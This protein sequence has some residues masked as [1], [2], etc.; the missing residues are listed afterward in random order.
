MVVNRLRTAMQEAEDG[1]GRTEG[2]LMCL[3][4]CCSLRNGLELPFCCGASLLN[5]LPVFVVSMAEDC[6]G[7]LSL[8]NSVIGSEE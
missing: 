8:I 4:D 3:E 5:H 2:I 7:R 1:V 6:F